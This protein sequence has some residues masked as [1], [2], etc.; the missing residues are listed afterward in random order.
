MFVDGVASSRKLTTL[1]KDT[2]EIWVDGE[3]TTGAEFDDVDDKRLQPQSVITLS[4][5]SSSTDCTNTSV[6]SSHQIVIISGHSRWHSGKAL[7]LQSIG[8]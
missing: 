8:L 4:S 2:K 3:V 6:H 5:S 7:D 1:K